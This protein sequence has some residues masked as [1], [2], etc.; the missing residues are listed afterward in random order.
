MAAK[1]RRCRQAGEQSFAWPKPCCCQLSLATQGMQRSAAQH[2]LPPVAKVPCGELKA[3]ALTGYTK[4][5]PPSFLRWHLNAYLRAW[6]GRAGQ[7]G[8]WA[9]RQ[10]V[11]QAE[12]CRAG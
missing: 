4:S 12:C 3:M 8:A 5:L 1:A 9:G 6:R 10:V 11:K 7:A 2:G